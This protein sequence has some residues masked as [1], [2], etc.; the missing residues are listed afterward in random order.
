MRHSDIQH[1][2]ISVLKIL[3]VAALY[4]LFAHVSHLYVMSN[5]AGISVA[6]ASS[7]LALAALLLG[8][9]RYAWSVFIGSLLMANVME[10]GALV[11]MD[12]A[13]AMGNALA[14]LIGAWLLTRNGRFEPNIGSLRDFLRL[15]L[16][17]GC[18][19]SIISTLAGNTAL[20]ASGFIGSGEYLY[21]LLRWWMGDVLGVVLIAPLVL[22]W[23]K[24]K[25]THE[26]STVRI[27][28]AA[29]L[30]GLMFFTG[31]VIF[32]DWFHDS[33]GYVAKVY[34][35]FLFIVWVAVRLGVRG[36]TVALFVTAAQG[37]WG[38]YR[39]VG[40]FEHDIAQAQLT[41][42]WFFMVTLSIVGMALAAYFAERKLMEERLRRSEA[43]LRTLYDTTSEAVML[44]DEKG[45][46]DCN[47][48]ALAMFGCAT[49]EEFC[50]KHPADLSPP[51]QPCGTDS[52]ALANRQTATA[53]KK[54]SCQFEWVHRR[55]DSGEAFSADVLLNRVELDGRTILQATIRDITGR[56]HTEELAQQLSGLLHGSFNEIYIFD[57]CSLRFLL[58]S[59]GAEKN[60]GYSSDELSLLTQLDLNPSFTRESFER[61]VAPLRSGEQQSLLFEAV[62]RRKAGTTYP[63]EV[64]LQLMQGQSPVF[65]AII[66]DAS[67]RKDSEAKI[68]RLTRAY[69]LLTRVNEAIVR[70]QNRN[71]L[72]TAICNAAME[73][74]LFRFVWI[75]MLDEQ[76]FS[77]MPVAYAGV[78][79]GYIDKLNNRLDD[80]CTGNGPMGR[81]IREGTHVVCHDIEHDPCMAP[82][83]DE[84]LKRGYRASAV[85][86]IRE[87]WCVVG[88]I[89]VYAADT[90]F[91]TPDIIQLISELAADVSFALDVFAER[92]R[93]E[94]AED[95]IN[96][97]NVV[98]EHRV[99]ERTCQL[100][101]AN[102]ELEAFSYSVSHDLRAPL[103]SIDGFS[104]V[105]L[106]THYDRLDAT[107]QDYLQRVRRASQRMGNLIDDL[108]QL[109]Q[110]ARSS[111]R[112]EPVDLSEVA[113]F[114]ADDLRK[115]NP[116]RQVQFDLQQ[117]LSVQADPGLLRIVMENLLGNAYKFTAKKAEAKIEFGKYDIDGES[118]FFVRDNGDGFNMD[119]VHKLFGA[120]QRLHGAGEFEGTGIGLATVQRI[121]HRHN[122]R[123][124]AEGKEGQGATFCFTLP[125]RERE[126]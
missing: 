19:A 11:W 28:E 120:F 20:L 29:L 44:L 21:S 106:K 110:V 14:A 8:G 15:I 7:G 99:L 75:G 94:R 45:F 6:W 33:V 49:C 60:L 82:W 55:A 124:W 85:F 68:E 36:V 65:I 34:W 58:T 90:H 2:S 83:R 103:R 113:E 24:T 112:R 39:E 54:G 59:E 81:A 46:F 74:G 17:G 125:Q 92:N 119:Y 53:M 121:I 111:I 16:L 76:K 56:K 52:K 9:K 31:Q 97:L 69:R 79:E 47:K 30:L 51:Q 23:W 32:F 105:L 63:V 40:F 67:R 57:A 95:E 10:A 3:G 62:H 18:A 80:V 61:L 100:E 104:Q 64:H 117:G 48:A 42:F 50:S 96:Q 66:Q 91:F 84:A 86:P 4:A 98:L 27:F 12:I 43:R 37:L 73:S 22:S 116:E 25:N 70:A 118:V 115:T 114:V 126:A 122:G 108:L 77:V 88:A 109:S 102:R 107:G 38:A 78:E 35:M 13:I 5:D 71:G 93:R 87:E 41:N 72:F 1:R 123:I 101:A 89:N 26:V